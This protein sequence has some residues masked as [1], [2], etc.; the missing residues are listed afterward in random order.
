MII[1]NNFEI[2]NDGTQLVIDVETIV[3]ETITSVLLWNI[4]NFKDYEEAYDVSSKLLQ[5]NNKEVII[6]STEDIGVNS[7]EDIWFC[8]IQSSEEDLDDCDTC[9]SPALGITYNLQPYYS[10]LLESL[11]N[12]NINNCIGCESKVDSLPVTLN[13]IIDS[14][15]KSIEIG[16][17]FQAI[18][19]INKLKKLC[20]SI[21]CNNCKPTNC[22]N[23]SKFKQQ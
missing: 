14:V 22:T 1:L 13:L 11:L 9:G 3:G 16:Y 20:N 17:Y 4:D 18:D 7:F 2:I 12:M 23:C 10:C 15:E 8:E 21:G 19:G 6:I 5:I